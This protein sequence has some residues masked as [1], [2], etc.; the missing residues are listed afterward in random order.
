MEVPADRGRARRPPA[1]HARAR[2]SQRHRGD[3]GRAA[4]GARVGGALLVAGR[5]GRGHRVGARRRR[6]HRARGRTRSSCSRSAACASATSATSVSRPCGPSSGPRSGRS[7][8][9][10]FPSA[11]ARRSGQSGRR[12]SCGTRASARDPHALPDPLIGFLEPPDAF[13]DALGAPVERLGASELVVEELARGRLD[14]RRAARS[15][16]HLTGAA[17]F[18]ADVP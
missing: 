18:R 13:L 3:R 7:T 9:S 12:R 4:A 10:S 5:R 11:A 16:G 2:R 8:C 1:R 6:R 17:G 14:D 15:A